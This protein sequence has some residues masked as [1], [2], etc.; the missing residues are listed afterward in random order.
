MGK[1]VYHDDFSFAAAAG[2]YGH[3]HTRTAALASQETEG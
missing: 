2:G 3:K 1:K